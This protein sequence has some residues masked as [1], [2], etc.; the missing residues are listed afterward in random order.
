METVYP[1]LIIDFE[2]GTGS[3]VPPCVCVACDDPP[4]RRRQTGTGGAASERASVRRAAA[5]VK[6]KK[7]ITEHIHTLIPGAFQ[8]IYCKQFIHS[9]I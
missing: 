4:C 6:K 7:T 9:L 5:A 2:F 3:R 1:H 8:E